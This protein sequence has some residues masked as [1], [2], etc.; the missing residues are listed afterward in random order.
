LTLEHTGLPS[1]EVCQIVTGGWT[2]GLQQLGT[3]LGV[4]ASAD[5][6]ESIRGHAG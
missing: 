5:G 6:I 3:T 2:P 4:V 1:D